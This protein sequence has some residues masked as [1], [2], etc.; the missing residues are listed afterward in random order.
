M[1]A[2]LLRKIRKR[3]E[4]KFV[5]SAIGHVNGMYLIDNEKKQSYYFRNEG[6]VT[7]LAISTIIS[8]SE[9]VYSYFEYQKTRARRIEL[10]QYRN[11]KDYK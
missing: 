4:W 9:G 10:Q 2:K 7:E 11:A 6:D 3:F 5:K 8:I 1:K